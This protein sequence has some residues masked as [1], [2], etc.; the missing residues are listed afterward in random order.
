MRTIS[1]IAYLLSSAA[2]PFVAVAD[3]ADIYSRRVL[4]LLRAPTGSSCKECHFSGIELKDFFS[5]NEADTFAA[6]K[7]AGWVNVKNPDQSKLLTFIN[8]HGEKTSP[9]LQE[10]R[11]QEK[12]AITAW[13]SSAVADPLLFSH[14]PADDVGIELDEKLIRHLRSDHVLERFT[15]NI[16]SVMGQCINCHSPERN[17]QQVEKHGDQMSWITPHDP[18]ATLRYLLDA[19]LIDREDPDASEIR[20]K[21]TAIVEHGGGPK[22]PAGSAADKRFLT[23]LRDYANVLNGKYT[24]IKHLPPTPTEHTQLTENYLRLIHLP[25]SWGRKLLRVDLFAQTD[26]GWTKERIATGDSFVAPKRL[27]WQSPM[28]CVASAKNQLV[29]TLTPGRYLAH[30]YVDR[31]GRLEKDADAE[32]TKA[33]IVATVEFSG[34]WNKGWKEPKIVDATQFKLD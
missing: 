24:S 31:E 28:W 4:P 22:F 2:V 13:L 27:R 19:G 8:R 5:E 6:L 12:D 34:A 10:V 17:K 32:F 3:S 9:E 33:D 7:A 11:K 30:I 18:E 25:K 14:K 21:P 23:F 16:W 20:T 15:D 26:D 1:F 29:A